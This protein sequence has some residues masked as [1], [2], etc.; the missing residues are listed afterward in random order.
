M[1]KKLSGIIILLV[2][3]WSNVSAQEP[4]HYST[5]DGL[6]SNIIYD[7]VQD[8]KGYMWFATDAG[9]ARFDGAKFET[10][11]TD[12]GLS[13]KEVYH[14]NID[15]NGKV[16]FFSLAASPVYFDGIKFIKDEKTIIKK[17]YLQSGINTTLS[18]KCNLWLTTAWDF[19]KI[20]KN[21]FKI[22]KERF[23]SKRNTLYVIHESIDTITF[24][25]AD[26]YTRYIGGREL[27]REQTPYIFS[28]KY[29]NF[30]DFDNKNAFAY[31]E[32]TLASLIITLD[33]KLQ[34][35]NAVKISGVISS[36]V[37]KN[38]LFFIG[39]MQDGIKVYN[40]QFEH[41][42]E[43]DYLK[44]LKKY[45]IN[46]LYFDKENNLW[47][48]TNQGV[49]LVGSIKNEHFTMNVI[50]NKTEVLLVKEDERKKYIISAGYGGEIIVYDNINKKRV[51]QI[52]PTIFKDEETKQLLMDSIG[53]IY[54]TLKNYLFISHINSVRVEK[55][56]LSCGAIKNIEKVNNKLLVSSSAGL[57]LFDCENKKNKLILDNERVVCAH[58]V[59]N[60]YYYGTYKGLYVIDSS[61]KKTTIND[62]IGRIIAII[63]DK[64]K[65]IW[66][67]TATN[68]VFSLDKKNSSLNNVKGL[69][70]KSCKSASIDENG[71]L[72]ITTVNGI[73]KI[74]L[75]DNL[76]KIIIQNLDRQNGILSDQVHTALS[77]KDKLYIATNRGLFSV[78]KNFYDSLRLPIYYNKC[79]INGKS[80]KINKTLILKYNETFSINFSC[81]AYGDFR[82]FITYEYR[83]IGLNDNWIP[84]SS[85]QI[86]LNN[87][88]PGNYILQVIA[89][90]NG[91]QIFNRNNINLPIKIT[92]IYWQTIWFK[93]ITILF[94]LLLVITIFLLIYNRKKRVLE[95]EYDIKRKFALLELQFI[96]SQL[97]PH[98]IYNTLNSIQNFINKSDK[99]NANLYLSDFAD[100]M[101]KTLHFSSIDVVPLREEI[102]YLEGYIHLERLRFQNRFTYII[103]VEDGIDI[104]NTNI[105]TMMLQPF[106]ENAIIHGLSAS[107]IENPELSITFFLDKN[108][109][110]CKVQDNGIGRAAANK[111][112]KIHSSMSSDI[113]NNRIN[114]MKKNMLYNIELSI[115]DEYDT[116]SNKPIGTT[117]LFKFLNI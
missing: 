102:A 48:A 14:L 67:I 111:S 25:G 51:K 24:L 36:I 30:I 32:D 45:K 108:Y 47:I 91:K 20:Q 66:I 52:N 26:Y 73:S 113:I 96:K 106:V 71:I 15:Q 105:I 42:K 33:N 74:I 27:F 84:I 79:I 76:K 9:V 1:Q 86:Q 21:N 50:N 65:A 112:E 110:C 53:N 115:I 13:D 89:V 17:I 97:N 61:N 11:T 81:V 70:S 46:K 22:Y 82:N 23:A 54:W 85:N 87:L 107:I 63:E 69:V 83:L 18:D 104:D 19:Y 109:L 75:N 10:F 55:I 12:D 7:C 6:P 92:P 39:T 28:D 8:K 40:K 34:Q 99:L 2:I 60:R 80:M 72:W 88:S 37:F 90:L 58:Q 49:L 103:K 93:I 3:I 16:W 117:V 101:R 57:Y 78:Y 44:E 4:I 77:L 5:A 43:F 59:E 94:F 62:K 95:K 41:Q 98:F 35:Q 29:F 31:S 116:T 68:G 114:V 64:T 100:L 38:D 56:N